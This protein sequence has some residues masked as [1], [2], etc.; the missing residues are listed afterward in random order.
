MVFHAHYIVIVHQDGVN[1]LQ[2]INVQVKTKIQHCSVL[3]LQ[4]RITRQ[5]IEC[6]NIMYYFSCISLYSLHFIAKKSS[7]Q[8]C[9]ADGDTECSSGL[10]CQSLVCKR[11]LICENKQNEQY[12]TVNK[13]L[14]Y[15]A[16]R[17]TNIEFKCCF[18]FDFL[19]L[20]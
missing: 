12:V 16:S 5:S 17:S 19:N 8:S 10:S 2:E 20:C 15:M 14:Y 9:G 13:S 6:R 7:G 18:G 1:Q 3:T 4:R 11:K